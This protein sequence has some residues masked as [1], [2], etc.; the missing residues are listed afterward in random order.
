VKREEMIERVRSAEEP[1]DLVVIGGGATGLGVAVDAAA[2]GYRTL[3]LEARDFGQGTSSRSTKLV[4]GGVRYL[5]QGNVGLV[6]EALKERAIL[7]RNAPHLVRDLPFVVPSYDWWEG[8][9]YGAGLKLYDLLAGKHGFGRSRILSREETLERIPTVETEGLR[10]GV[11]YRDGQFDDARLAIA[12]ART[13]ADR[14]A[15]LVNH[16]RVTALRRSGRFVTGAGAEDAETGERF[17]IAARC[18]V[19]AAGPFVDAVRRL[20]DP[21]IEPMIRPSQG[22]HLVLNGSFL[23][24]GHAILLPSTDDGRVLFLIPWQGSV[25]VGTTDTPVEG[26][27]EEPRPLPEEIEFLLAHAN[28]YLGREAGADDVLSVFAGL[29]PLVASGSVATAALSRDHSVHIAPSGLVTIAGGKWTTYRRMAEDAVD[30]AAAVGE[31]EPRPCPTAGLPIH[32]HDPDAD[33]HGDLASYGAAAPA[34]EALMRSEPRLAAPIHPDLA[35]RAGCF[36]W[37]ARFEMARTVEDCLARRTRALF[38]DARAASAAAPAVAA[39]LGEEL[40][41]DDA[42]VRDQSKSFARLAAGYLVD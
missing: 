39:L 28:R 12:L 18:V 34:L 1:W 6:L 21:A 20:D 33:R 36:A 25:V 42:W 24:R 8:P 30:A 35:I 11:V 17:E 31:L 19:N 16:C 15:T 22:V 10:G 32:G 13:A 9:F 5:Q 14:G 27:V 2:R 4:H 41:R 40:G 26:P 38:L 23:P 29:R 37:A 7:R 3:L